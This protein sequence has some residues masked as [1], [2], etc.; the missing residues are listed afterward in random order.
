MF[1]SVL[2]IAPEGFPIIL[3]ITYAGWVLA[4]IGWTYLSLVFAAFAL[5]NLYFFRD[6]ERAIP[7]AS[8]VVVSPADGK[9]VDISE[10]VEPYFSSGKKK[11]ISIFLSIL[12]CHV[13]RFPISG[14]VLDRKREKGKFKLAFK[15]EASVNN[16][17][18]ATLVESSNG[19]KFVVVQITGFLARRIVSY[20]EKGRYFDT[21]ERFGIIRYGSRVDLFIPGDR[22]DLEVSVGD[23]VKAGETI[24]ACLK[25]E[26]D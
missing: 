6:P 20:A 15:P 25:E 12:D 4:L 24:V 1:R 8:N 21:G 16:E 14:K 19:D 13:N 11:R 9:V 2:K 10:E 7:S 26:R 5:F 23:K 3:L 22:F 17:R 18:L